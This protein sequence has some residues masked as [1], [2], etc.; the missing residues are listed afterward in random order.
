MPHPFQ[1]ALA[2]SVQCPGELSLE[3]KIK[4]FTVGEMAVC[5]ND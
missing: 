4:P 1:K 2:W 3:G 5:F